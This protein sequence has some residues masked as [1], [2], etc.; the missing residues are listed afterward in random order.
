MKCVRFVVA[1]VAVVSSS[2]FALAAQAALTAQPL[3]WNVIGLDSNAPA[4]G[5]TRF[6]VGARIC[7]NVATTN[8]SVSFAWDSA[9]AFINLRG[10]SLSTINIPSIAAGSCQD[11][12]FEVE[13]T[14]TAAAFDTARR[15]HITAT[16]FSG[17]V[18]T[19]TPRELY[20]EHLISQN[21]NSISDVKVGT[22]IPSLTSVPAGG[23]MNLVVGNT[24]LVQLIGGTATQGYNQF[25]EFINFSNT[26]F[27]ILAVSTT[28]SA[29]NS[30]YVT[31]PS[32]KLYADACLWDN[33]PNSPTYRDCVGGDFKS[34]GTNVVTTYTI[35]VIGGGGTA[36][37]LN[38]LL[39]DFSGSSFHY[40]GDYSASARIANIIDPATS[41]LEKSF[42]PNPAPL[43]GVS[44]LT[45]TITN[46]NAGSVSGYNFVD[47]LP[48]NLVVATPPAATTSGCGTPA[49]TAVAGS[50]SI[51]FSNGT[52]AANSTCVIKVN[53]TPTATGTLNNTTGNLFVGALDTGDN[54]AASLTVNTAPPPGTG[55]CGNALARWNF[56]TGM[57]TTAPLPTTA[58]VTA[59]ASAGAGL[60]PQFSSNDN[61]L[62][63]AGTGS[64][65]SNGSIATGT[66]LSTANNDFF[67]FAID[68]TGVTS[69][70]LTFDAMRS[71][72]GPRGV[73]VYWGNSATPP[74][75]QAFA[76]DLAL[77][78][79]SS[80]FNL[81][82][83]FNTGLNPSGTTYFRIYLYNSSNTN[84][85]SDIYL[86]NVVFSGCGAAT[87]PTLTKSFAP[88]P[89]AVGATSTLTFTLTNP[90]AAALTAAAF[91]DALPSGLQVAATPAASTT[92]AGATW[93][94][95]AAATTVTFS[96]GTIPAGGSCTASV[97]I[98]AT[99]A[100]PHSNVGGFLSTTESGT[101]IGSV[102][103]DTLTAV[104]PP[105]IVKQFN[106][107]PVLPNEASTL[108]F[109]ITN[110]NQD[111]ALNGVAFSD[112]LPT[113][114]GAMVV[115][116]IPAAA[117][118]GCGAPTLGATA[119]SGV[120]TLSGGTIAAGGTCVVTVKVVVPVAGTYN[121]TSG[122]VSHVINATTINGNTASDTLEATPP[123]PAIS[124]LKQIGPSA[125]GPW[126][127]FLATTGPVYYRF[128]VENTGDV[129][130]SPFTITDNQYDVSSCN[131]QFAGYGPLPVAVAA[132][133]NH[134]VTCVVGPF[135]PAGSTLTNTA[136]ATGTFSATP[137]DSADSSAMFAVPALTLVKSAV[138]SS[139]TSAGETLS[140]NYLVTNSGF[141]PLAGPVTVSDDKTTVTCPAVA[142][143][144]DLDNF[145]DPGE[146]ITCT[147]TYLTTAGDVIAAAVTN[148]A[149]ATVSGV[150]SNSDDATVVLSTSADVSLVKTLDTSA[151]FTIGQSIQYTLFIANAGPSTATNIQVTDT[152]T[153]LTITN[154]SG[155]GCAALP[156]TIAS[157][158]SG[159]NTSI[160][161]TATIN[162]V[163]AF[164]NSANADGTEPDPNLTNNTDSSGNNGT[165]A[166]AADVSLVKTLV[167]AGPFTIGQSIQYTLFI[168]N[169]GPSTATN[170]QVTDTP[171]NLTIT[172]VSGSGCAALPCTIPTLASG[173]NTSITVTATIN[174]VGAFDNSANADGDESDPNP[175]NNT[176]STG[177][178]GTA[179]VSADV[180]LVKTLV[181]AGPFTIGQ[182]IQYTLFIAN[183]GPSTATNVQVTD[184]P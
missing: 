22:S 27:Q 66:P 44:A 133:E 175:T 48:A 131:G 26:V 98:T 173:A 57:S 21:R 83:T 12:Y 156:C 108:T 4:T 80:W 95:A 172:N 135:T 75:T 90:N 7:S 111:D 87:P 25:E 124:L 62:A 142:M 137:F 45:F 164:D 181:T 70:Q 132:N 128:T 151:P 169:A 155:S 11:A 159:A 36:E 47:N 179:A 168:A 158:A 174:A 28:Y 10:G 150:H 180:S 17:S 73:A 14:A 68:T 40:N 130:L 126:T 23:S 65:S 59:T 148:T 136:H 157:L 56:P 64:W 2:L 37:T 107:S 60:A 116:P 152:P 109:T 77:G 82:H 100:G 92:C 16:D 176:D 55:I 84:P 46:P 129:P 78:A 177:N 20:V 38:A 69:L 103:T 162:A 34:G 85:G 50:G 53:V 123:A 182:S 112:T 86:D 183:A 52:V 167:T 31:S 105:S 154:V 184:T 110:P 96:G 19:S 63:P 81:S 140:Y 58:S 33:D 178:D 114:P 71:N 18:S 51:S 121:N 49:L 41:T 134:I 138:Q 161:V 39:Y 99:T 117:T 146:S 54:A 160:T 89:I 166:G 42:S 5:P 101:T 163:G 9:N 32:D 67:E 102:P 72:N 153:D 122:P 35:Q 24:Y 29:N 171:T 76:T 113:S 125:T 15:Y 149:T 120:I 104:L 13:V 143:V 144:G 61:T 127:S 115:A 30:P 145:L 93:A 97:N 1:I 74:G 165:A 119:G 147:A 79:A 106:P 6:P 43:N 94:P 170:I 141:A 8:V 3:T 118:S 91:S 88:D 139:F